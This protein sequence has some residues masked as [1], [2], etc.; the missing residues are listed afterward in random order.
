MKLH[1]VIQKN[2]PNFPIH[3]IHNTIASANR[4]VSKDSENRIVSEVYTSDTIS[5]E[6]LAASCIEFVNSFSFK[7]EEFSSAMCKA[8]R[9]LQQSFMRLIC[10]Y[11]CAMADNSY[12]DRNEAAVMLA[13]K[14]ANVINDNNGLP[15]I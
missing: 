12:D 8:H 9:T 14:L 7:E 10:G 1:I 11:I 4:E 6:Q 15:L 2:D 5:G 3:S 13:K